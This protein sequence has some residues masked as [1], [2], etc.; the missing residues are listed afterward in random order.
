ME[1]GFTTEA[2]RS[3]MARKVDEEGTSSTARPP[4]TTHSAIFTA[5]PLPPPA[6]SG[7]SQPGADVDTGGALSMARGGTT[8][9]TSTIALPGT[10]H[11]SSDLERS[12]GRLCGFTSD[13][14]D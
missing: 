7:D 6:P 3:S 8:N 9:S 2:K 5:A 12:S 1:A 13:E 11:W 14:G 10:P 4:P